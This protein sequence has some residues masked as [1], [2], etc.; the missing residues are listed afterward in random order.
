[1]QALLVRR[2]LTDPNELAYYVVFGPADV[3]VP[4]LVRVAGQRW[5][6]EECF[7]LAKTEVGLDDYDVRHWQ[8]WYRHMTLAM[9]ALAFLVVTRAEV[10]VTETKQV[11]ARAA[12]AAGV[13]G[14]DPSSALVPG[15]EGAAGG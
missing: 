14:R 3:T 11:A 4:A 13:G 9:W 5:K 15:L 7:E 12:D 2:S 6:V 10:V 8:G 1:L